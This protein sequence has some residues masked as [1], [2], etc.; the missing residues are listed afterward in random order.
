[1]ANSSK[2]GGIGLSTL[3]TIIFVVLK[4]TGNIDW[5]WWWVLSPLWI[6]AAIAIAFILLFFV[7]ILIKVII[8]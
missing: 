6:G 2:S 3:L 1:M 8:K 4:L 5:N 7:I